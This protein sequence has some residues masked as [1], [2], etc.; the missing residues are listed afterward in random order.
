[1]GGLAGGAAAQTI[2]LP[3]RKL[4]AG[5]YRLDVRL[6]SQVDPGAVKRVRS[7]LLDLG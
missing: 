2:T 7:G 4:P 1:M 5:S 6:V 3:K